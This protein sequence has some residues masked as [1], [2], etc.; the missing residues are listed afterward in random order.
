M[1]CL[2][3]PGM[4][5]L[6]NG[7]IPRGSAV[8][9]RVRPSRSVIG[10]APCEYAC[11]SVSGSRTIEIKCSTSFQRVP[12]GLGTRTSRIETLLRGH[13]PL[14]FGIDHNLHLRDRA[15]L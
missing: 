9:Q 11:K 8:Y 10:N 15:G 4:W 2:S 13:L 7:R 1:S 3:V 5:N 14:P 12:Q 6:S